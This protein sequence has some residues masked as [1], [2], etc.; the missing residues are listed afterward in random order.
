MPDLIASPETLTKLKSNI[1]Y[2]ATTY[3]EC[4]K[5]ARVI[6]WGTDHPT[7][8]VQ[9]ADAGSLVRET[10]N[11]LFQRHFDDQVEMEKV[12]RHDA[13]LDEIIGLLSGPLGMMARR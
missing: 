1:A 4:L 2:Y 10:A 3:E 9:N 11:L 8:D 7:Q 12:K 5:A 13:K 6:L